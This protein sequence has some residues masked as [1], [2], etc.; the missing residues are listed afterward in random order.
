MVR[1]ESLRDGLRLPQNLEE[2]LSVFGETGAAVVAAGCQP[3]QTWNFAEARRTGGRGASGK[4][5]SDV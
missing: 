3:I 5:P 2:T 4:D 1:S